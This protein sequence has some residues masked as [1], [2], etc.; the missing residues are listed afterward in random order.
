M[1]DFEHVLSKVIHVSNTTKNNDLRAVTGGIIYEGQEYFAFGDRNN[2][3]NIFS[4]NQETN[5]IKLENSFQAHDNYINCLTYIKPNDRYPTGVLITGGRDKLIKVWDPK[6]IFTQTDTIPTPIETYSHEGDLLYVTTTTEEPI[7]IIACDDHSTCKTWFSNPNDNLTL[8]HEI[9]AIWSACSIPGGY[10]TCGADRTIRIWSDKGGHICTQQAAHETPIRGCLFIEEK[11]ILATIDNSGELKE[12]QVNGLSIENLNKIQVS[13]MCLYSIVPLDDENYVISSEDSCVYV[14]SSRTKKVVDVLLMN[15]CVWSVSVL[16]NRDIICGCSDGYSYIF[17]N[18]KSRRCDEQTE[19]KY[20]ECLENTENSNIS[21]FS[22]FTVPD[23]DDIKKD[24]INLGE[25]TVVKKGD[26][27]CSVM[28]SKGYK[29]LVVTGSH[30]IPEEILKMM[31]VTDDQGNHWDFLITIDLDDGRSLPLYMN[32]GGNEYEAA[33]EF[34]TKYDLD[35]SLFLAQIIGSIHEKVKNP[36]DLNEESK[37][38]FPMKKLFYYSEKVVNENEKV[39]DFECVLNSDLNEKKLSIV[40]DNLRLQIMD[41]KIRSSIPPQKIVPIVNHL[42]EKVLTFSEPCIFGLLQVVVNMF[43]N[44]T[45]EILT[46]VNLF[47][48]LSVLAVKFHEFDSALQIAYSTLVDN[49]S[50]ILG[51]NLEMCVKMADLVFNLLSPNLDSVAFLRLLYACGNVAFFWEEAKVKVAS[52][53]EML[54]KLES[55]VV[56]NECKDALSHIK[57]MIA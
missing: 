28:W 55:S 41:K 18:G 15:C 17:T 14:V 30:K 26:R 25:I 51:F 54:D 39:I 7:G 35:E 24:D 45:G 57:K 46:D 1:L 38:I 13:N 56:S 29:K 44:Y 36:F 53:S 21:D 22:P 42:I 49:Y 19:R 37:S 11:Q 4:Y 5:D 6:T 23:I 20:F 2:I 16:A 43:L 34:M 47:D 32:K 3:L 27:L 12:W 48:L 10:I 50:T 31:N 40:L 33:Q 9:Y 8:K 52:H